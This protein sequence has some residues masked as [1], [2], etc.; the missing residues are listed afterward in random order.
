MKKICFV[1]L[2]FLVAAFICNGQVMD[3]NHR[4][5]LTVGGQSVEPWDLHNYFDPETTVKFEK[6]RNLFYLGGFLTMCGVV[7]PICQ[8]LNNINAIIGDEEPT[9]GRPYFYGFC[10]GVAVTG[11]TMMI[12]GNSKIRKLVS[13]HNLQ[14]SDNGIGLAIAF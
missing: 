12:I 13:E 7:T 6:N 11:I 14:L 3:Y 1:I 2:A 10:A 8:L 5:G 9:F 4:D